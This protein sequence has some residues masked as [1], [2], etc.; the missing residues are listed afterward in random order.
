ML[1]IGDLTAGY[2]PDSPVLHDVS[3]DITALTVH[4]VVG[5][6]GAGKSTLLH[7]LAGHLHPTTGWVMLDGHDVT[8]WSPTR[9]ARTGVTLAPQGRRLWPS[10]TVAEHLTLPH[11]RHQH[12]RTWTIDQVLEMFPAL[13]A[14]LRHRGN[15]LSGGEQ[16]MLTIA[17]ALRTAPRLLLCDEP[18][19]GLA[20][21][22]A[23]QVTGVLRDLPDQGV[24]VLVALPHARAAAA[25]ATTVH[26]LT[27]G[28]LTGPIAGSE[29]EHAL[30]DHLALTTTARNRVQADR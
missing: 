21:A 12:G 30:R 15:Q 14:R 27:A 18:T 9:A 11:P 13:T 10:L 24:T 29:A 26:V 22:A 16:Q 2:Q 5:P 23:E 6:N 1:A 25:L 20:P 17:R 4:A 8:G 3:L 28:H 7:T 19:E